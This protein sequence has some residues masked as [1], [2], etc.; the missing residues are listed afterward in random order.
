MAASRLLFAAVSMEP[1]KLFIILYGIAA[2]LLVIFILNGNINLSVILSLLIGLVIGPIWPVVVGSCAARYSK[3]SGTVTSILMGSA[4]FGGLIVPTII[5]AI[6]DHADFRFSFG[7][8]AVLAV[9]GCV[10]CLPKWKDPLEEDA[11]RKG[12]Q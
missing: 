12:E 10:I 3:F 8:L 5:G 7:L 1:K 4:G 11:H 2:A 6:A 9:I